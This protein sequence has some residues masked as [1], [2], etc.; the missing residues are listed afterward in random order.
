MIPII[1][2]NCFRDVVFRLEITMVDF[3]LVN[4]C[5]K[6]K[7]KKKKKIES[8][9]LIRVLHETQENTRLLIDL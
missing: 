7:K 9:H 4:D 3:Q 6:K 5:S 1:S 2:R 8:Y